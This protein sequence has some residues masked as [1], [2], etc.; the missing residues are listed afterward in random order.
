M[1]KNFFLNFFS[2][3][4][5][6]RKKVVENKNNILKKNKKIHHISVSNVDKNIFDSSNI[7]SK[8][9]FTNSLMDVSQKSSRD[10]DKYNLNKVDIQ[11]NQDAKKISTGKNLLELKNNS[12]INRNNFIKNLKEK[13]KKTRNYLGLGIK[14]I[15][16]NK[17]VDV[18]LFNKLEEQLLLSDI[19][20]ATT[21][22]IINNLKKETIRNKLSNT[23]EVYDLLKGQMLNILSKV[24]KNIDVVQ[25]DFPFVIL[26]VGVNGVGKTTTVGKLAAKYKKLG[27]SVM[28]A[29]GDTFRAAAIEQ[30]KEWGFKNNI[31][32]IAQRMNADPAAVVF[33]AIK[34]AQAK[35]IDILIIDTAGRLHNKVY[36]MN[37][38][39]KIKRVVNKVNILAPHEIILV[40]DACSGQNIVQQTKLF[41]ESLDLTGIVIT[42]LDGT[43][44]GGVIFSVAN[45][46]YI[47]IYYIG[48]GENITDLKVFNSRTFIESIF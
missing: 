39:K 42:K 21:N 16:S 40:V 20:F 4:K 1:K 33:D 37:E 45:Q 29:A 11:S 9:S 18:N 38:L 2:F 36:L 14:N 15:F 22:L 43:A 47:P 19:G 28:L 31:S 30:L 44:K 48:T 24:E 35:K 25:S 34:S 7:I 27:K 17:N 13:L 6:K 41:H 5:K 32:V 23:K 26:M 10:C 3:S 12:F 8:R 46:F